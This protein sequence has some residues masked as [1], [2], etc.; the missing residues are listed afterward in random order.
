MAEKKSKLKTVP[1]GEGDSPSPL[2]LTAGNSAHES[3]GSA[4]TPVGCSL[5]YKKRWL[6][7]G[8]KSDLADL[9]DEERSTLLA[10]GKIKE[11]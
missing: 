9:A 10:Q 8:D 11:V 5:K 6:L 4:Y 7:P 1:Q 2:R 3:H